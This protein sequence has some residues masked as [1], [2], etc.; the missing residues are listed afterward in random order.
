LRMV[1]A[2]LMAGALLGWIASCA[3]QALPAAGQI[4][5]LMTGLSSVLAPD[6]A[7]GQAN[8]LTR[9][10]TVAAPV[11]VLG[12]GLWTLPVGA[13]AGSYDLIPAGHLLDVPDTLEAALAAVAGL[14]GLAIRLAAPVI[15]AG[16]VWQVALAML[17]RLVPQL[18]VFSIS[19]PGRIIGG[20]LLLSLLSARLVSTWLETAQAQFEALPG[21]H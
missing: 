10:F 11:L 9:L 18:Q 14:F 4:A 5:S 21:L 12:T 2:E 19:A 13:L 15:I 6:P 8:V 16:T 20:L 3:V 7:V 17:A 1:A